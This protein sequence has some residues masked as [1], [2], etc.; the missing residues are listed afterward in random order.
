M[1]EQADGSIVEYMEPGDHIVTPPSDR[2]NLDVA[3]FYAAVND[4]AGAAFGLAQ[5]FSRMQVNS[6]YTAHRG[7]TNLTIANISAAQ[8]R[9]ER[10][11]LDW[12]AAK[13]IDFYI[14]QN[15]SGLQN[16]PAGWRRKIGW[17]FPKI[18]NV[19]P[20]REVNADATALKN[21]LKTYRE[22]LGPGWRDHFDELAAETAYAR[23]KGLPLAILE[24]VAGAQI[25]APEEPP[26]DE[27]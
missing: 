5:G 19:D 27:E 17:S 24:T 14:R 6:S 1:L 21:G 22:I 18:P 7:E 10:Q 3:Q 25:E 13:V 8:K 2:P 16:P 12:L 11:W 4:E 26:A 23:E 15:W 9:A 20:Q